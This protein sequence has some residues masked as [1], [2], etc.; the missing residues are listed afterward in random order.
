M[1]FFDPPPPHGLYFPSNGMRLYFH[2]LHLSGLNLVSIKILYILFLFRQSNAMYL[3]PKRA[4][5]FRPVVF[6]CHTIATHS[7]VARWRAPP[8]AITR[9]ASPSLC[10]TIASSTTAPTTATTTTTTIPLTNRSTN[11]GGVRVPDENVVRDPD[12]VV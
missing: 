1:Y 8:V 5:C 3:R 2:L 11:R 4:S 12:T 7:A 9:R 6:Q 10:R